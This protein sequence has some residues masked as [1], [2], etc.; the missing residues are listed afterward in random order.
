MI[1]GH[2]FIPEPLKAGKCDYPDCFCE[3]FEPIEIIFIFR[4]AIE[5]ENEEI[6]EYKGG[7][8]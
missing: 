7:L 6:E 2:R 3:Q 1:H 5:D 8:F 4:I